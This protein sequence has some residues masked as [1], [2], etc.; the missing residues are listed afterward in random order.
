[1]SIMQRLRKIVRNR[2]LYITR[3]KSILLKGVILGFDENISEEVGNYIYNGE[4]EAQEATAL[5]GILQMGDKVLEVG[6]GIG[7]LGILASKIVGSNNVLSYEANPH[8]IKTIRSNLLLNNCSLTI[9]N[10]ILA[11]SVGYRKFYLEKNFWSS[12][13]HVRE[14]TTA[15]INVPTENI[16]DVLN[17][18][19]PN[20]LIM[21]IEGGEAELLPL[22]D[23][24]NIQKIIIEIHPHVIGDAA[25]TEIVMRILSSGFSINFKYS[26]GSIWV[27]ER[28]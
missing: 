3:P 26:S 17:E 6:A 15:A 12:S 5:Q 18:F 21:D 8:L 16:F 14:N 25:S 13:T 1:M 9:R 7:F 11:D 27:F 28:Y 22:V 20:V 4:Y 10:C 19:Q 23:I 2:F 24:S